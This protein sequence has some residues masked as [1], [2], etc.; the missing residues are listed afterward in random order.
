MAISI[1]EFSKINN[2]INDENINLKTF[3]FVAGFAQGEHTLS[4]DSD[5]NKILVLKGWMDYRE[6]A[7]QL[8]NLLGRK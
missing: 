4:I 2:A 1:N 7:K 5:G 8:N 3:F 6:V